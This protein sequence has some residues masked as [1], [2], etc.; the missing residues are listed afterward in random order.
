MN[1]LLYLCSIKGTQKQ[2][3]HEES[4]TGADVV[5]FV[6]VV[7]AS[8]MLF[9]GPTTSNFPIITVTSCC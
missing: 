1:T 9:S 6:V 2:V 4:P 3:S 8:S 7:V 5:A